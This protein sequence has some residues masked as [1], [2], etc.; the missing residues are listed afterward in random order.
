MGRRSTAGAPT[1]VNSC[2]AKGVADGSASPLRAN[3]PAVSDANLSLDIGGFPYRCLRDGA[4][5]EDRHLATQAIDVAECRR[6][7]DH[8]I[9]NFNRRGVE[10]CQTLRDI[11]PKAL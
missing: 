5:T 10:A 8:R 6:R 9:G 1:R 4:A 3:R 2:S 11:I 7:V